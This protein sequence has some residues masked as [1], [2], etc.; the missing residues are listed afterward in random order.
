M[1]VLKFCPLI[2]INQNTYIRRNDAK[3]KKKQ[4]Q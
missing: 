4:P 2:Y 3:E 1:E